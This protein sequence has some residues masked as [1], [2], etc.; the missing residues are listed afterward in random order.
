MKDIL[1]Q[2]R[3]IYARRVSLALSLGFLAILTSGYPARAQKFVVAWSAV[4]ALN[5]PFW[6]MNDGGIWKQE[7]LDI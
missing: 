2:G 5:A 7:G 1:F 4:S 6:V 3:G